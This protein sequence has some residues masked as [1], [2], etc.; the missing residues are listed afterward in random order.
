MVGNSGWDRLSHWLQ[1]GRWP[2]RRRWLAGA[3]ALGFALATV[4][5]GWAETGPGPRGRTVVLDPGHGGSEIG[6][7]FVLADGTLLREKD[8]T[9]R[10]ARRVAAL[11]EAQGYRVVLTRT[12]DRPVNS[13]NRDLTGDGWVD[14]A[15]ELQARI[16]LA[17]NQNAAVFFS[18]HFNGHFDPTLAGPE[19]Y[20]SPT[21]PLA[22][23]NR[24][25][26]QITW[27]TL[28]RALQAAG[29]PNNGRGVLPDTVTGGPLY[30][31][32]APGQPPVRALRMPAVLAEALYLTNPDDASRLRD[33]RLLETIA[34][35]Y[36]AALHQFLSTTAPTPSPTPAPSPTPT[37]RPTP[38][39][40][41][42]L[43]RAAWGGGAY[44]RREPTTASP[45]ITALPNDSP[46]VVVQTTTGE[47]LDPAEPRWLQI[48]FGNLTG[49]VY[50]KLVRLLG[51]GEPARPQVTLPASPTPTPT[52]VPT[53]LGLGVITVDWGGG[54]FVRARP[55]TQAPVVTVL[56]PDTVVELLDRATGEAVLGNESGWYRVRFAGLEGYVYA[57]L[58]RRL[59]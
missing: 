29:Y 34:R 36:A 14:L 22:A 20:Y 45:P 35:A 16:D 37:P 30:L 5:T 12:D 53:R 56:L 2:V 59:E 27:D 28:S 19:V 24:R 39:G 58:I 3:F 41:L 48:R 50:R 7:S 17:N 26:A 6:A 31:L 47:A 18:I 33:E 21:H 40:L 52:P 10:V 43:I 42:G 25:L 11:L 9:L 1:S 4:L 15:D 57:P 55:T 32:G 38:T 8:L 46:V 51:E 23:A 44:V 54:A 13:E 49:Y